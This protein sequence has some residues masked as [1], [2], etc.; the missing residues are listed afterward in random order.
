[1]TPHRAVIIGAGFGGLCMA[2]RLKAAGIE[3]FVILERADAI[4]G[5]WRDNSYPGAACDIPAVFYSYSFARDHPWSTAYP[6]Q[7]E[8]L[9]Y[10]HA[11][12]DRYGLRPHLR[13]GRHVTAARWDDAAAVWEMATAEGERFAGEVLVP[14]VGIFNR[15]VIPAIPGAARFAGIAFHSSAWRHDLDFAG[16]RVAVVGTGS[17]AVQ[18]VPELVRMGAGVTLFQ[19]S[20]PYVMPK[21]AVDPARPEDERARLFEEFE[22]AA[23]RRADPE[24]TEAA[25]Q[26]FLDRLVA[27]VPDPDL[28]ARLTPDYTFG[29]KRAVFSDEWFA[30]LQAPNATLVTVPIAGVEAAGLRTRDG[31]LHPVEVLVWATGFDPASYLPGITVTGRGGRALHD[32]WADGAEAYL[33]MCVTGF[34]NMFLL[35]GPNTNVPGSILFMLECQTAFVMQALALMQ[36]R[37]WRGIDVREGPMRAFCDGL[38]AELDASTQSAAHCTS[39]YMTDAGRVVTNFPGSQ[40]RYRDL[41][42]RIAPADFAAVRVPTA[43]RR[44]AAARPATSGD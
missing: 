18:I 35:Y 6:G 31:V 26:A 42:A 3:D 34:P 32:A 14:A 33:G 19:R 44:H 25:R 41:T 13:L 2:I 30:A 23:A 11:L 15:P 9:G 8:I 20:A 22:R 5:V 16:R 36:A 17:S 12:A 43:S 7:A 27:A 21:I 1:M 28:R 24:A 10:I 4:G 38:R 39:Y 40:A 37:G 29:C